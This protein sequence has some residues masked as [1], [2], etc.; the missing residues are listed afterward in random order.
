M[1]AVQFLAVLGA[2]LAAATTD[3]SVSTTVVCHSCPNVTSTAADIVTRSP[4]PT[5]PC[6]APAL[7]VISSAT[8]SGNATA[9]G[10]GSSSTMVPV[11]VSGGGKLVESFSGA[12]A[13]AAAVAYLV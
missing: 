13:L 10:T 9:T 3:M 11:T 12:L 7:T 8:G 4:I 2:S 6:S 1:K 5:T